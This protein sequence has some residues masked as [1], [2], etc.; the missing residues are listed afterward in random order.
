MGTLFA[1]DQRIITNWTWTDSFWDARR[2]ILQ[3]RNNL[4]LKLWLAH[5]RIEQTTDKWKDKLQPVET[6]RGGTK[7][8]KC[9]GTGPCCGAE[10]TE[11][12]RSSGVWTQRG[13]VGHMNGWR[14]LWPSR[15]RVGKEVSQTWPMEG[16]LLIRRIRWRSWG[17][18]VGWYHAHRVSLTFQRNQIQLVSPLPLEKFLKKLQLPQISCTL[19][20][21]V[22]VEHPNWMDRML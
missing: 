16:I 2:F 21:F 4:F 8:L 14:T 13:A 18:L 22:S 15:S 10:H 6:S 12:W 9:L 20:D 3:V 11:A 7:R 1:K 19:L 5:G 17:W